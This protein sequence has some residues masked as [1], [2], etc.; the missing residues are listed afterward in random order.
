MALEVTVP[1]I[2]VVGLIS[3]VVILLS[4][5]SCVTGWFHFSRIDDD[6]G[7]LTRCAVGEDAATTALFVVRLLARYPPPWC[8]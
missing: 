2:V 1:L 3:F 7:I 4:I 6:P 8:C 5:L